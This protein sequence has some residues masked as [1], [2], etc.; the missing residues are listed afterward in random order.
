VSGLSFNGRDEHSEARATKRSKN[1]YEKLK[2]PWHLNSL[3]VTLQVL[4]VWT[5]L[6]IV[7]MNM[8]VPLDKP[9]TVAQ[10]HAWLWGLILAPW[11]LFIVRYVMLTMTGPPEEEQAPFTVD[12]ELWRESFVMAHYAMERGKT[13]TV[14]DLKTVQDYSQSDWT[15]VDGATRMERLSVA[16]KR[17]SALNSPAMPKTIVLLSKFDTQQV[18]DHDSRTVRVPRDGFAWLGSVRVARM[19]LGL[20]MVLLPVFIALALFK[21]ASLD[22]SEGL[23]QGDIVDKT[24]TACYLIVAAGLGASFAALFKVR[25]YVENLSYDEQYESSYWVRFV[26]GLVAGLI[27]SVML[28]GFLPTNDD[29]DFRISVPILALVG[30]FSSDLVYRI[31]KRLIDAIETLI[32][33]S[34]SEISEAEKQRNEARLREQAAEADQNLNAKLLESQRKE[35]SAL[36]AMLDQVPDTATGAEARQA[37]SKRLSALVDG[38][39]LPS[40]AGKPVEEPV[41][42]PVG[43][44]VG[45]PSEKQK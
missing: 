19:M 6:L 27:L 35:I 44:P 34:A 14:E 28:S 18:P 25:R 37:L 26:L 36:L 38:G 22:S 41:E 23:I 13:P 24:A 42:E 45:E 5:T 7:L 43:E 3:W 2:E 20:A 12:Y 11:A 31:L 1:K 33:G 16:H 8:D 39:G 17:L 9:H 32:Q 4:L 21:G 29:A 15:S 30:G 40:S 10:L